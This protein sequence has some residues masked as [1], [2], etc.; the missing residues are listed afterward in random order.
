MQTV[1]LASAERDVRAAEA[2]ESHHAE[3]LGNLELRT[4]RLL[5]AI[6]APDAAPARRARDE[7]VAWCRRELVPHAEAEE[8]VLYPAARQL[9]GQHALIHAMSHEHGVL[10]D[11]VAR[12]ASADD[13]SVL[14]AEA[15]ALRRLF[16][17]H[18]HKENALILPAVA[19]DAS[20][21]LADLLDR[22]HAQLE[23]TADGGATGTGTAEP[24]TTDA[25]VTDGQTAPTAAHTCG[26]HDADDDAVELDVRAVP[27][28]I[29][30]A[31][32]F[33]ALDA[34]APGTGIVLVAPHDPLPLLA[35]IDQRHPH[36]F[37]VT[38]LERGPEAWRLLLHRTHP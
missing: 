18:V 26:C 7:L 10:Q 17:S 27:H 38:Y 14:A 15:G 32:V 24:P 36:A 37:D 9:A 4:T 23:A 6:T 12:L 13:P 3:L 16:A 30:H 19:A 11:L 31:T 28:A 5:R 21:S 33:G 34:V 20:T 2:M 8:A 25:A 35:Q 1:T 22:M 29:R